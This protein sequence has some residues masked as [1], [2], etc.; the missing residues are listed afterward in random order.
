MLS[1]TTRILGTACVTIVTTADNQNGQVA[2]T[3][4]I[5]FSGSVLDSDIAM[6]AL[7]V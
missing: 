5:S 2:V 3:F 7:Q 1:F 4:F 6:A